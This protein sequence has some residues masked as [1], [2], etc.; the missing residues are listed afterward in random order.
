M[1]LGS[2][3]IGF[4]TK[5][6]GHVRVRRWMLAAGVAAIAAA[7]AVG[8]ALGSGKSPTAQKAGY[9]AALVSDVAGFNDNGF[10]KNQLKGL[11]KAAKA[12]SGTAFPIVSDA[13]GLFGAAGISVVRQ[14]DRPSAAHRPG[15]SCDAR[16]AVRRR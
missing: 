13:G 1:G 6:G 3:A 7:I 15:R 8:T 11:Q 9:R 14:P 5:Q 2:L 16:D 4:T 12:I 10:N